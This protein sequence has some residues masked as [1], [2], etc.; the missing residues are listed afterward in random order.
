MIYILVIIVILLV[1]A[2][3]SIVA[4]RKAASRSGLPSGQLIY[5]DTGY[6]TG[7]VSRV[8]TNEQGVKQERPL[9]S[10]RYG[11]TGRP[12]YLVRTSEGIVPVEAKSTKCPAGGRAYDSHVMQLAAYCLL[13]EDVLDARVPYGIIRYADEEVVVDYSIELRDELIALLEEMKEAR[14]AS[15][16]H[17]NHRDARRCSRC[18]MRE[19]CEEALA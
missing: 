11:L 12:D 10:R 4:A 17:R 9:V 3:S 15:D 8:I 19:I 6:P 18:S 2:L 7:R 5:S 1:I 16:V 13:V 14:E